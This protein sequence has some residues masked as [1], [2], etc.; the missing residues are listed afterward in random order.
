MDLEGKNYLPEYANRDN[1]N[2]LHRKYEASLAKIESLRAKFKIAVGLLEESADLLCEHTDL[3]ADF[4]RH[5]G[6][7]FWC[8]HCQSYIRNEHDFTLLKRV[9]EALSKIGD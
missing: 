4:E 6:V 9:R 2:E 5:S 3:G 8:S 1:F 7:R